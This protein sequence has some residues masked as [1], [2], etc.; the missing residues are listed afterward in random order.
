MDKPADNF[1][2]SASDS[3]RYDEVV[4]QVHEERRQE[5]IV[6]PQAEIPP[7]T[8]ELAVDIS[9]RPLTG[10]DELKG[11]FKNRG[12]FFT[13][14]WY[15][16]HFAEALGGDASKVPDQ[17]LVDKMTLIFGYFRRAEDVAIVARAR[18]WYK[19]RSKH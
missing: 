8:E 12:A 6:Q 16:N 14:C 13:A 19:S 3:S 11:F 17:D 1:P 2:T 7:S 18:E 15:L 10:S 9:T 5:N 4:E